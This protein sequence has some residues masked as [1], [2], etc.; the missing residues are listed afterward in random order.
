M[1]EKFPEL[2]ALSR[3]LDSFADVL[4]ET[5]NRRE[6]R[7][8]DVSAHKR[9]FLFI[10]TRAMKS[11]S[12]IL[13]LCKTGYA[14]DVATLLRS[15]LEHLITAKYIGHNMKTADETARR[16]VDYKWIIF[17][18]HLP[19]EE[20]A[21]RSADTQAAAR[22]ET[23]KKMILEH[24]EEFKKKYRITSDRAF[25]TWSGKTVK[26]M[27]RQVSR[28]LAEEY[29]S[30]FRMGS[31]F[32]HPTILGDKEYMVQD[33]KSLVFSSLPSELGLVI[34]LRKAFRYFLDFL[35]MVNALFELDRSEELRSLNRRYE[36]IFLMEKHNPQSSTEKT[37]PARPS[38]TNIKESKVVF[39]TR[40]N[41]QPSSSD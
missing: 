1:S 31:R 38:T 29:E 30:T 12:A 27:A 15:F 3:D 21:V 23:K 22:F 13:I 34:N 19:E 11:Y 4:L 28:V 24:V 14:Q 33:D 20:L 9:I 2:F 10:L 41:D 32:S 6:I 17:K 35:E 7:L 40:P 25:L 8:S 16:F 36:E 26:D 18:R 39:R 5:F 37:A